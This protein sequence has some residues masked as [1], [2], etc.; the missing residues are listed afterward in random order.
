MPSSKSAKNTFYIPIL[1]MIETILQADQDLLLF[2]NG[3]HS[4]FFDVLL[5]Q[6]TKFWFWLPLLVFISWFLWKHYRKKVIL[7]AVFCVL[8]IVI[9]DRIS[10]LTKNQVARLRPSHN[11]EINSRL[12]LHTFDNGDVYR[13][14]RYSFVSSHAANSFSLVLLLIYFF[15]PIHKR[16]RWLFSLCPLIFSYTRLYLGVHYPTDILCGAVLGLCCG[17]FVIWLYNVINFNPNKK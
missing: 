3:I 13:G 6:M 5:W 8:S 12:H 17:V 16:L 1:N 9:S 15:R 10:V 7:I 14:G 2:L 4:P 11:T